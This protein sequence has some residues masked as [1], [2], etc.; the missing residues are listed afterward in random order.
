MEKFIS[1][2]LV[3]RE[4]Q[5]HFS[6]NVY[7]WFVASGKESRN[8]DSSPKLIQTNSTNAWSDFL[9]IETGKYTMEE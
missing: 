6:N 9:A 1:T 8:T 5:Q 2:I 7:P 3:V 4:A